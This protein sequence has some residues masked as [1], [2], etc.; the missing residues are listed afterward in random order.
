MKELTLDE[1]K[2]VELDI[3][4]KFDELCKDNNFEYSLAYGTMIGAVRHKGFIPWDDDI[5]VFMKREDYEK[6][7]SLMYDDGTYEIKSYRYSNNYYYP[8]SKMVDKRTSLTEPW[9]CEKNMGVYIDI[10]PLDLYDVKSEDEIAAVLKKA[11]KLFN[12]AYYMGHRLSHHKSFSVRYLVKLA[13][14]LVTY[15]FKKYVIKRA[16]KFAMKYTTG[17]YRVMLEQISASAF[18]EAEY[19]DGIEYTEFENTSFPVYKNYDYILKN[20]YGDYMQLPPKES[21]KSN[22][23]F[24]AYKR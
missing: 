3:L 19:F 7:L 24:T 6:L 1:I 13:Y 9:R 12:S 22:H 11:T 4:K 15:P 14:L 2:C 20:E 23:Y 8:F 21:R 18:I 10:F 17:N 5:D 16:E